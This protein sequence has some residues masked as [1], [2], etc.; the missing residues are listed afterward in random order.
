MVSSLSKVPLAIPA[1]RRLMA[2]TTIPTREDRYIAWEMFRM[3]DKC[4]VCGRSREVLVFM[5][6]TEE[7]KTYSGAVCDPC[8]GAIK[9]EC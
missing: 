7:D 6:T 2:E 5:V 1:R 8:I 9:H 3:L 4:D